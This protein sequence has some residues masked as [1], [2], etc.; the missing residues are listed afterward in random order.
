MKIQKPNRPEILIKFNEVTNA[1]Q[2][3]EMIYL[4]EKNM[5]E[6]EYNCFLKES[7]NPFI[8]FLESSK[9]QEIIKQL[10]HNNNLTDTTTILPVFCVLNNINYMTS[11]ILRKIRHKIN[12]R[13]TFNI[14]CHMDSYNIMNTQ[15][16]IENELKYKI[17]E[18]L[19]IPVEKEN[20]MWN[21]NVYIIGEISAISIERSNKNRN[22]YSEYNC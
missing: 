22:K 11:T 3:D 9:P 13:D 10:E 17:K 18:I 19:D 4:F 14:T 16:K 5:E 15:N 2:L 1:K 20:P 8:F 7:E 6:M 12:Y 21:I